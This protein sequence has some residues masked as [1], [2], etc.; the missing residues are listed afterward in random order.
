MWK[1]FVVLSGGGEGMVLYNAALQDVET[2]NH[3]VP[4]I[5]VADGTDFVAFM[6]SHE[7][8]TGGF[9]AGEPRDGQGDVMAAFSSLVRAGSSS[10]PTS[11]HR[12]CRSWPATRR[13]SHRR[14]T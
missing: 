9:G 12:A 1:S 6:A 10:S 7:A 2:D 4:T 3:W 14:R 11:P 13:P 5:H 8:V